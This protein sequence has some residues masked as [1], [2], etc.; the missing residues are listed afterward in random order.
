MKGILLAGGSGTRLYPLTISLSKQLLPIYNKPMIYYSLS[1]LMLAE[2]REICIITTEHDQHLFKKLLGDGSQW[3]IKLHYAVQKRP[4]GIAQA[5]S[6]A[7]PYLGTS[8]TCLILG[9]NLFFGSHLKEKLQAAKQQLRGAQLFGY[10]V[11]DP[12]RYGVAKLQDGQLDSIVEKPQNP[13][14]PWAITGLYFYDEN[15]YTM[16]KE[17][18][19]SK[20][21]ELEITDLN[22][23]YIQKGSAD[24]VR[25]S[26]G[27]AWL[28]TGTFSSLLQA[29]Q[30]V[31]TIEERQNCLV[32][33][34][35][36]IAFS[37]GWIG[38]NEITE[39]AASMKNNDYGKIL[40][41]LTNRTIG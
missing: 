37:N 27:Y 8:K 34:V 31:Q 35:E 19:P 21:G 1:V 9:D 5:F 30:Y 6:I 41:Q 33:S 18:S 28:D 2:I 24:L 20:R 23:L 36:E 7:H 32:A 4:E 38:K 12:E 40:L 22:N 39:I 3:G 16:A 10:C 25:L 17:L 29:C 14:S 26:R 15:V 13:P 11:K